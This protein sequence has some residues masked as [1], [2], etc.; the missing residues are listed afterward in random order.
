MLKGKNIEILS[1]EIHIFKDVPDFFRLRFDYFLADYLG[2][3]LGYSTGLFDQNLCDLNYDFSKFC[4]NDFG[5]LV[6]A[7]MC[8]SSPLINILNIENG[9]TTIS[10]EIYYLNQDEII[11]DFYCFA[12]I[13]DFVF[14]D[15][16]FVHF[17]SV[18][19]KSLTLIND[20]WLSDKVY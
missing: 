2:T 15:I 7:N 11:E 16:M 3:N 14:S 6:I 13:Y 10:L 5:E 4:E 12:K 19:V 20:F 8:N 9:R 1:T 17:S 18:D